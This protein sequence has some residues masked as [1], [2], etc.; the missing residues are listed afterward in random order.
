[1]VS[2]V[3]FLLSVINRFTVINFCRFV[4]HMGNGRYTETMYYLISLVER[5]NHIYKTTDWGGGD[6]ELGKYVGYG[7]QID[8]IKIHMTSSKPDDIPR[9]V[10]YLAVF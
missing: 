2:V 1:M 3:W 5:V 4:R 6:Y 8:R 7:F 9:Y 10:A